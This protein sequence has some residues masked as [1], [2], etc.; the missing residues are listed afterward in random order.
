MW[1]R[2]S[3]GLTGAIRGIITSRRYRS[4]WYSFA[5]PNPPCVITAAWHALNPASAPRYFAAFACGPHGRPASY[6]H[7]AFITISRAAS[8][9]IQ[10]SAS[11]CWIAWFCPIG[12]PKTTRSF[13]YA[14]ARPSA[15]K[16]R[17][18]ASAAIR[19][20][21]GFSPCR[22]CSNPLPSSPIRSSSGTS[23]PSK[24]SWFESTAL[25]PIFSISRTSTR[26][27]SSVV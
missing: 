11:G 3:C 25:R 1:H 21:S 26:R 8:S 12:R 2:I 6:S 24:K 7:A 18:T 14:A 20:R 19:I 16:P 10:L 13:A 5:Y 27:R 23:N 15:A 17:P 4:T 22:M 9:S